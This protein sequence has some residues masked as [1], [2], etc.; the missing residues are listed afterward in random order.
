MDTFSP[1]INDAESTDGTLKTDVQRSDVPIMEQDVDNDDLT[2]PVD[3]VPNFTLYNNY[4]AAVARTDASTLVEDLS[5]AILDVC[6]D[7]C[8]YE[9]LLLTYQVHNT[10][11]EAFE[12]DI[13]VSFYAK[14]GS[15]RIWLDTVE[16]T[17]SLASGTTTE[18][19]HHRVRGTEAVEAD[20]LILAI[21]DNG[22]GTGMV[23]ECSEVDNRDQWPGTFCD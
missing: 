5:G 3:P 10:S 2:I 17:L 12:G 19:L 22:S 15:T 18:G 11:S 21:D 4:H 20:D 9:A 7:D 13:D 23:T 16:L 6:E 8:E 1:E 14:H